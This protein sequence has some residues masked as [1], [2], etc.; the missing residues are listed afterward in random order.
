M[1]DS[2]MMSPPFYTKLDEGIRFAV[3]VLHARGG[4]E[5]C[6]SCEGGP[7]H[8]YDRPTIDLIAQG[9]DAT[10]FAALAALQDYGLDVRDVSIV[11]NIKGG[12]PYEKIWRITFWNSA[13]ERANE[14]PIFIYRTT[15]T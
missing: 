5:T 10:G 12:L 8:A 4:I 1:S 15:S 11:W 9:D 7:G 2:M 13:P 3:R 6:Q 14:I